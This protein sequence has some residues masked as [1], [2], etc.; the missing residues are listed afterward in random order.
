MYN[1]LI[2]F[3]GNNINSYLYAFV[4]FSLAIVFSVDY[5]F[6]LI[7]DE[8]HVIILLVGIINLMFNL[9]IWYTYILGAIIGGAIFWGLGLLALIIFKKEGMGFGDVKLMAALGFFFGIKPIL[10]IALVSFVIGAVL[11]VTLILSGR[12]KA[13]SYIPFGPFI[14]IAAI[15]LMFVQ[16]DDII[17]LYI[18]FCTWLGRSFTD[19]IYYFIK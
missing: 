13:D 17:Y 8:A 15:T 9:D 2:Y 18:S 5:R 11:G 12:Q 3:V 10:V 14:V 19:I 4:I 7:P 6:Q 1:A 16:A